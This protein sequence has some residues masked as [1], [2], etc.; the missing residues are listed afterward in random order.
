MSAERAHKRR[1]DAAS[2]ATSKSAETI[3][4]PGNLKVWVA[5]DVDAKRRAAR[6]SCLEVDESEDGQIL[7]SWIDADPRISTVR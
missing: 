7:E 3:D 2:T 4:N 5:R 1:D 6:G